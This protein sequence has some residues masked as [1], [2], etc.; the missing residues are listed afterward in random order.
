LERTRTRMHT[1]AR[2]YHHQVI[3]LAL[4]SFGEPLAMTHAQDTIHWVFTIIYAGAR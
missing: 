2:A 1:H 3:C 4:Q